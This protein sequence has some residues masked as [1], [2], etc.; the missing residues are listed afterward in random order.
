MAEL[1]SGGVTYLEDRQSYRTLKSVKAS[2]L[3]ICEIRQIEEQGWV[4]SLLTHCRNKRFLATFTY[5]YLRWFSP[6][7][8]V[9][10][11]TFPRSLVC[12]VAACSELTR[13]YAWGQGV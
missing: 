4:T 3:S 11:T 12:S 1:R 2:S 10:P 5:F 9:F 13:D 7:L 8:P 6:S